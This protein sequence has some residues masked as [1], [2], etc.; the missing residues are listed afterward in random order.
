MTDQPEASHDPGGK[1]RLRLQDGVAGNA[2]FSKCGR[3]RY[4]LSRDWGQHFGGPFALWI[5]MNPSTAAA[6]VD[7]PTIRREIEFTKRLGLGC[8][9][10]MNVMD[11]RATNQKDLRGAGV[12][13]CSF[14]NEATI[15]EFAR[16]AKLVIAAW[17]KLPISLIGFA[18]AA[19]RAVEVAEKE[20]LCLG[21]NKDGSPKH[22][23]YVKGD[24]PF[25]KY[26]QA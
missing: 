14:A 13:P 16:R 2:S 10:K 6:D 18:D 24:T 12:E 21:F 23:L 22:P 20:L 5:G 4:W 26:P 17:G 3:Y 11:Y 15:Y 1:I 25:I 9:V 8:Y 19:R 7:D